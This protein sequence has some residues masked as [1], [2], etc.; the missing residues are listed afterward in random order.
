MKKKLSLSESEALLKTLKERFEKNRN[1][2]ENIEWNKVQAKLEANP[3][4]L[5]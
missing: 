3:E 5:W 1:R 2:H 4:K